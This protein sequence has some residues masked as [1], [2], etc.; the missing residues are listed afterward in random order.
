VQGPGKSWNFLVYDVGSGHDDADAN[1]WH[2]LDMQNRKIIQLQ[3]VLPPDPH[4]A[5]F[6]CCFSVTVIN[7]YWSMDAA[8]IW[9]I[10]VYMVSNC[11]LSLYLNIAGIRQGPGKIL[12][13]SWK[14]VEIFVIKRVGTMEGWLWWRWWQW[15]CLDVT[16]WLHISFEKQPCCIL[17]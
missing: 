10:F 7:V 8:I 12:L 3:G 1:L 4:H 6:V 11:C 17:L 13:E 9:C 2:P 5:V 15:P 16:V 14:V